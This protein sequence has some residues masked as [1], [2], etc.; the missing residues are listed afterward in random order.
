MLQAGPRMSHKA[1][2]WQRILIQ[3]MWL[4]NEERGKECQRQCDAF[5][6]SGVTGPPRYDEAIHNIGTS[7]RTD[8]QADPAIRDDDWYLEVGPHAHKSMKLRKTTDTA[9]RVGQG[10]PRIET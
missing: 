10:R 8:V 6:G 7:V 4:T 5:V 2:D 1:K 9:V 3:G